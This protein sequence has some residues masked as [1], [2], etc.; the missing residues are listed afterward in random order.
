MYCK[1]CGKQIADDSAFCPKCG[2]AQRYSS[3]P[4]QSPVRWETCEIEQMSTKERLLEAQTK[5]LW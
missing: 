1:A 3:T 5:C 2:A 4:A